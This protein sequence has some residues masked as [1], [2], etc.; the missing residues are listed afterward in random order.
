MFYP[1]Y[2][3]IHPLTRRQQRFTSRLVVLPLLVF[4]ISL[5]LTACGGAQTPAPTDTPAPV[6]TAQLLPTATV[7]VAATVAPTVVATADVATPLPPATPAAPPAATATTNPLPMIAGRLNDL[8]LGLQTLI[9]GLD[10]PVFITHAGDGS[11]RL[12]IVEKRGVIRIWQG[13]QL[14]EPPFLDIVSRVG[15]NSSEQGLLGLAFAPDFAS[16]R[17]I[18]VNYTNRQGDT[19]VERYGVTD[20]PNR[21]DP[22]SAFRILRIDQPAP[23]HNGGMVAFGPDGNLWIGAG[24]GGGAN[25]VFKN[26]QNPRALLGKML[27]LDVMSDLS[28]PYVTP[29]DNPWVSQ[30]WNGQ[31]VAPEI[32]ALGL[33]NPWRFSFDRATGDLWIGDVGQDAYEEIDRVAAEQKGYPNGGLNFG[34]PIMEGLHCFESGSGCNRQGLVLPVAEHDH[35]AGNC[36]I[37]GGY[38]YRGAA[39]PA[40]DAVYFYGDYCSGSVWALVGASDRMQPP[41]SVFATDLNIS[42][43]GEDE[44]GE[45]YVADLG[46]GTVYQLVK[47]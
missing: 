7:M 39:I 19:I 15:S 6:A 27:R 21:A 32:W 2:D 26:G 30:T 43:F 45:L 36:S 33:R 13:N 23:N 34:W 31:R 9:T 37:T 1:I 41:V 42:S 40:L 8:T 14:L 35:S 3:A 16:S 25:D 28:K 22:A 11:G 10:E 20:D 4:G 46:R 18:F 47:P 44:T 5:T 29:A 17:L 24:D 38:V 12:F